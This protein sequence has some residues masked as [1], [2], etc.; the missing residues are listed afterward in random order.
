MSAEIRAARPDDLPDVLRILRVALG[1]PDGELAER[2]WRWKHEENPFGASPVWVGVDTGTVVA[3]RTFLR[4]E[5]RT[6][7]GQVVRAARAVDT[8]T[9]PAHHG[10]GWFRRLTMHGLAALA[11]DGFDVVFNTPNDASR[12]GYL[13]MGWVE[14]GRLPVH[15]RP[16][17]LRALPQVARARAAADLWPVRGSAP[18]G[19]LAAGAAFAAGGPLSI[20]NDAAPGLHTARS[21]AFLR[22]RYGWEPLGYHVLPAQG[23]V[24]EG[25][26]VLR[27][28]A[29][30]AAR[31]LALLELAG[32]PAVRAELL[33]TLWRTQGW[34]HAVC[35]GPAPGRGWLPLLGQGP[36][37]VAR[38]VSARAVIGDWALTLGDVELL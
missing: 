35:L 20:A 19:T 23:G 31:E 16:A 37:L 4:W 3:V 34:D 12:P 18:A 25:F 17:R 10:Q 33:R 28:R 30:G 27:L 11:A 14:Q 2:F 7:S 15:L 21:A 5:L 13:K 36:R 38:A 24:E 22:W 9:D 1:W 26:A 32:A 29:R 6:A 8:A